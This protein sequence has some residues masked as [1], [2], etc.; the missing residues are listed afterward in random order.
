MPLAFV[1]PADKP[2]SQLRILVTNDDGIH[3][4]GLKILE[5]IAKSL[6]KDVWIVAPET[7]QSGAGHSLTLHRPFR[8]RKISAKKYA[9]SGTPTDCAL[10][11]ARY[12][13]PKKK[14]IDLILSGVNR[15]GNLAEDVTYSGTIAAAME[16]TLLDIPSIAM[17]QCYL[18]DRVHW[19]TALEHAPAVIRTLV[20][21]GWPAGTLININFPP[22]VSTEVKGVRAASHGCR[23][24]GEKL[25]ER[26]DPK[27]RPYF[28]IGA[29]RELD[30]A[31]KDNDIAHIRE[32]YITVTPIQMDMTD[33]KS[34]K[35]LEKALEK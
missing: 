15:G 32:G 8:A 25:I 29:D 16:G 30:E 35:V 10:F 26:T 12:I 1:N 18:G 31:Q 19:T 28:W 13:I 21:T 34:L 33:Y 20:K 6:S 24:I 9:V 22:I 4:D 11:A 27:G 17:S 5:K 3:A 7:E 2:L 14:P 23:K